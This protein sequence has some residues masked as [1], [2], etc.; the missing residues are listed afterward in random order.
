M[1]ARSLIALIA[2]VF[3]MATSDPI[4][5][6]H[7]FAAEFDVEKPVTLVGAVTKVEWT[8]PHAWFFID[9]KGPDGTVTNWGIEMGSINTLIR[10]GW[11]RETMKIGDMVTVEGYRGRIKPMIA[12]AKTVK[13]ADGRTFNAGSSSLTSVR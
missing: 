4:L 8:N 10:Y 9:V 6:H 11:F 5:A 2:A 7:S 13:L 1:K 3:L 12:N